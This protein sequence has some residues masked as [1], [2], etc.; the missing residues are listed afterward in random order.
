MKL[1]AQYHINRMNGVLRGIDLIRQSIEIRDQ[2]A[3]RIMYSQALAL[4]GRFD[5]A[6][7]ELQTAELMD[8][9]REYSQMIIKERKNIKEAREKP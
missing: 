6:M 4:S 5:E 8:R 3:S 7:S 2:V 9:R 1:M